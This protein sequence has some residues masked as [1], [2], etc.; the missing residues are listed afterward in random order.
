MKFQYA[1]FFT[2]GGTVTRRPIVEIVFTNPTTGKSVEISCLVD[3]GAD[4]ILLHASL[5]SHIGLDLTTGKEHPF[6]G[7]S[8]TPV[9]GYDHALTMKLKNDVYEFSTPCAFV[10]DLKVAGL[11]GQTGFF[12]N[13]KITFERYKKR[14][15][16]TPAK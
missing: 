1:P 12:E 10:P 7:I 16:I 11:V 9:I 5:A 6:Q 2:Y 4:N 14:F 8:H 15:E 3:S 13:Y